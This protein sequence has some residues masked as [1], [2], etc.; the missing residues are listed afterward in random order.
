MDLSAFNALFSPAG[1]SALLAAAELQPKE[2]DFLRHFTALSRRFPA[3]LARAALETAILRLEAASKFPQAE[4][5]YFTRPAL[6]QASGSEISAYRAQRYRGL[7]ALADLACSI[8][9]DTLALAAVAPTTGLDLDPL[10]LAMARANIA[11]AN[12]AAANIAEA[13]IAEA[14][15]A[16][17]NSAAGE[18]AEQPVYRASF[19]QADLTTGLPLAPV[20]DL[21][22]FFDPA[23]RSGGRRIFS[24]RDY[25][26]PLEVVLSWLPRFPATG[27]KISPGVDLGEL[28]RYDAEIEFISV[29]RELKEAVLWFGPLKTAPRR[30]TL[31]PGRHSLTGA[32]FTPGK[33]QVDPLPLSEP[34]ARLYEPDPAILRAGLVAE[35]G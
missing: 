28:G 32:G 25:Q 6:E 15:L 33:T 26:P 5:M 34:D 20:K 11:A 27:V 21:G 3:E 7:P 4:D 14:N 29:N 31:L 17:A 22:L 35:V 18:T 13:N 10:R 23:R 16:A 9:G 30:A 1:Q 12:I 8:G 19:G 24:V 2:S